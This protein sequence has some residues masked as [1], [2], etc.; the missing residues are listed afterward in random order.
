M[1][2][3]VDLADSTALNKVLRLNNWTLYEALSSL[4]V[5]DLSAA[6]AEL[7]ESVTD[8]TNRVSALEASYQD[9]SAKIATNTSLINTVKAEVDS[10]SKS[11]EDITEKV[12]AASKSIDANTQ[13]LSDLNDYVRRL[14]DYA[15]QI[16]ENVGSL[17]TKVDANSD[18]IAKMQTNVDSNSDSI[19]DLTARVEKLESEKIGIQPLIQGALSSAVG[20]SVKVAVQISGQIWSCDSAQIIK[21]SDVTHFLH[22]QSFG[23]YELT[24][25][26]FNMEGT[27]VDSS[28]NRKAYVFPVYSSLTI[29]NGNTIFAMHEHV[30]AT[31]A[32]QPTFIRDASSGDLY[33]GTI[34]SFEF[35]SSRKEDLTLSQQHE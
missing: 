1:F 18:S 3:S 31:F 28:S 8:L 21:F 10:Y 17:T 35:S 33:A 16:D 5:T 12:D 7:K 26:V 29:G 11:I 25:Y 24:S 30:G 6:L 34:V 27:F 15:N 13:G 20:V 23:S 19:K 32:G 14:D 4:D 2:M 9:L 22:D